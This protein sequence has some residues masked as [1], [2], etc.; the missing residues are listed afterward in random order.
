MNG[1]LW[2]LLW[3]VKADM[4]NRMSCSTCFITT[5][6]YNSST[7]TNNFDPNIVSIMM[8]VNII[9]IMRVRYM[10]IS[11]MIVLYAAGG[12]LSNRSI[13]MIQTIT[14]NHH[15]YLLFGYLFGQVSLSTR[16]VIIFHLMDLYEHWPGGNAWSRGC[17][18][19]W[20]LI[21][22]VLLIWD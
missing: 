8:D 20:Y 5:I 10:P 18:N 4:N 3:N 11:T 16:K 22:E 2:M 1:K 7:L 15:G 14:Q 19:K 17:R 9:K 13:Q 21:G 12:W 6:A